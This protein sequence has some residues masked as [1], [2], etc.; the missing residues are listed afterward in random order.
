MS[1]HSKLKALDECILTFGALC[2]VV[3]QGFPFNSFFVFE[4]FFILFRQKDGSER[5]KMDDKD[6]C[7]L[8]LNV[9]P[10]TSNSVPLVKY[11]LIYPKNAT[12]NDLQ[13][14]LLPYPGLNLPANPN[15]PCE[16]NL[17]IPRNSQKAGNH[18][19]KGNPPQ[20]KYTRDGCAL[21]Y[22][23]IVW[24]TFVGSQAR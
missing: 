5:V 2:L 17:E 15:H 9:Q 13:V 4:V 10:M 7:I 14:S 24:I 16:I 22:T 1:I 12:Q 21:L 23:A 8:P 11:T 20:V 6:S 19:R 18:F 3:G